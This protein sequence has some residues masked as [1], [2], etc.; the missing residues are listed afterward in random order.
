MDFSTS[1]CQLPDIFNLKPI[2]YEYLRSFKIT[3]LEISVQFSGL[4]VFKWKDLCCDDINKSVMIIK[5]VVFGTFWQCG[6][7]KVYSK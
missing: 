6:V 2:E 1:M 7:L 4:I 3:F 5:E